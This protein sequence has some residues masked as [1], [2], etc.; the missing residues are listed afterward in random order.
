MVIFYNIGIRCYYLGIL[1]ASLFNA[2]AKLWLSGRKVLFSRLQAAIDP[3][4]KVIWFHCSSLGEFEQGRPVIEKVKEI[5]PEKKILLTFYSP[6]GYEVR[7][8]YTGADYIFYMPLDTR[9]NANRFIRIVNP[10]KA[11]FIKYEYWYHFLKRLAEAGTDTYLVSAIFRK[12]QVFFKWYGKWFIRIL[13]SFNHL[14]VQ[15]DHSLQNLAEIGISRVIVSGDTRFDRVIEIA[16]QAKQFPWIEAFASESKTLVMGSTWQGDEELLIRYINEITLPVKYIIAPHE[17]HESNI[18]RIENRIEKPL[19]RYS[20]LED[21][22]PGKTDV[23][24]IDT[25][26]ILSSLYQYGTVAWIGGGFGKGIHNILEAATFGLPVI[27]GPNYSK[28]KE[29]RDLI[30]LQ[31]AFSVTDYNGL[32]G[33]LTPLLT[34]EN[35]LKPAADK[36]RNYVISREGA[37][38][39]IVSETILKK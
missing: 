32:A 19:A 2:K 13:E 5:N 7:K 17:V 20:R 31:A 1:L 36:A 33:M 34:N 37:T 4:D 22:D 14:F 24:V 21:A 38:R 27:F 30:E 15:D 12:N 11:F 28:F 39:I 26:G 6:S 35:L 8:D 29:A 9:R 3:A 16:S 18:R 25:I 23:L 10:E